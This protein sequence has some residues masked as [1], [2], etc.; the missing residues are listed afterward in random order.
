VIAAPR[1]YSSNTMSAIEMI[2]SLPRTY[3]NTFPP[4]KQQG[5]GGHQP[6]QDGHITI[7]P[8]LQ[9]EQSSFGAQIDGI[10]WSCSLS[11]EDVMKVR[12]DAC[13]FVSG[14]IGIA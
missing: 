1:E 7:T 8:V 14:I 9:D 12:T 5:T 4:S 10:D 13:H 3:E 6:I 11:T 2:E